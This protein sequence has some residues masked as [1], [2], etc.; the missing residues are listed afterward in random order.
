M[1]NKVVTCIL[2]A[3]LAIGCM[4][5]CTTR[6]VYASVKVNDLHSDKGI[7]AMATKDV[8]VENGQSLTKINKGTVVRLTGTNKD[9]ISINGKLHK[10]DV[11]EFM[12]GTKLDE[13]ALRHPDKFSTKITTTEQCG[14][15][16]TKTL[17][18]IARVSAG[19]QIF[20]KDDSDPDFYTVSFDG[21]DALL[22]KKYATSEIY[23]QV[24]SFD[25]T[26][27][28][29]QELW[30]KIAALR[31]NSNLTDIHFEY[32][33]KAGHE[34]VD[35]AKQFVGNPYVWGG[36]S[37]TDGCDCSGFVQQ[38]YKHFG[39]TLPRCSADQSKVGK[40][41]QKEELQAGD[42][43]F[44]MRGNRIGHVQ[45]YAGNGMVVHAKGSKYGIVLEQMK[46][47][48]TVC[49]R[50]IDDFGGANSEK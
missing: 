46:E 25:N 30:N 22:Y 7:P 21:Q 48:P 12:I 35:Y 9:K 34:I 6:D 36:T 1:K 27:V 10:V 39:V 13:Y 41:V 23:V 18:E 49:R 33:T 45:M 14:L 15:Y 16:D 2:A 17:K 3:S 24:K 28:M 37:L 43:L 38:V 20:V 44:F 11:S 31:G 5:E 40:L 8:I 47:E 29:L 50:Y 42:L 19:T 26:H 32:S 4:S